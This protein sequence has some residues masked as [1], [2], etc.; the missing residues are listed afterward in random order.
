[1]GVGNVNCWSVHMWFGFLTRR[2]PSHQTN[3]ICTWSVIGRSLIAQAG[4]LWGLLHWDQWR[5]RVVWHVEQTLRQDQPNVSVLVS[6]NWV[7]GIHVQIDTYYLRERDV[8][9][10]VEIYPWF[11]A[12]DYTNDARWLPIIIK[13][14]VHLHV[15]HPFWSLRKVILLYSTH[16]ASSP[17][18]QRNNH[19][20]T[21]TESYKQ[22]GWLIWPVWWR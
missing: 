19:V 7:G 15:N 9:L 10:Y 14:L 17:S 16:P 22:T 4:D 13:Y 6:D 12:L 5:S 20:S 1:M 2:W 8:D 18:W 21:T 3:S 11:F